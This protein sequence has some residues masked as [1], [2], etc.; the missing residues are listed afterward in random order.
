MRILQSLLGQLI[1]D[2]VAQERGKFL[3]GIIEARSEAKSLERRSCWAYLH[4]NK[5]CCFDS[6]GT[7]AFCPRVFS[8]VYLIVMWLGHWMNCLTWYLLKRRHWV[9]IERSE[10]YASVNRVN[11]RCS[12]WW[13][14]K[15]TCADWVQSIALRILIR[16]LIRPRG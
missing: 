14:L 11:V 9:S 7:L 10:I 4:L 5:I 6:S 2:E 8:L 16:L 3:L 12:D 13:L 1:V 15:W